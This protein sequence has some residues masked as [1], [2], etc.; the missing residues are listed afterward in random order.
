MALRKIPIADEMILEWA[1]RLSAVEKFLD[2][3][4][5]PRWREM[6]SDYEGV[7]K[8]G[9]VGLTGVDEDVNFN[10]LLA[11]ANS[12]LPSI[13][14]TNPYIRTK[15]RRPGDEDSA[16]VAEATLNYLWREIRALDTTQE[17]TLDSLLF[18]LGVGKVGYDDSD[19]F[20]MADDYDQGPQVGTDKEA[21][22]DPDQRRQLLRMMMEADVPIVTD[23]DD[24]VPIFSRVAPWNFLVP[25]GYDKPHKAPWLAERIPFILEDL[26]ADSRFSVPKDLSA[27]AWMM[28][29]IPASLS[30]HDPSNRH[31]EPDVPADHIVVYEIRYWAR[32]KN[33]MQRRILWMIKPKDGISPQ[34]CVLRHINDPMEISGY[35]YRTMSFVRVPG[36]IYTTTTSDLATIQ[37]ASSRLNVEWNYLLSHH[38][39]SSKRKYVAVQGVMEGGQLTSL[40]ESDQDM[41]VA[42]LP[43]ATDDIRKVIM[44]LPE[45]PPPSTTMTVLQ[46]LQ[47]MMYELSGVDVY[48]RGGV[49]RKGTT[50]TEVNVAA[51]GSGNRAGVRLAAVELF[52]EDIA[53]MLLSVVRQYWDEPR[54]MRIVG[55]T[56]QD[57]FAVFDSS[58]VAQHLDVTI[59]AGSA[60]GKDPAEE[61][62]AYMGLMTTIDKTLMTF[63][64]LAQMGMVDDQTVRKYLER[65]FSLWQGN[66][67]LMSPLGQLVGAGAAG[68]TGG[69][70][71]GLPPAEAAMADPSGGGAQ[72]SGPGGPGAANT[73]GAPGLG[74]Q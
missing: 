70:G 19:A 46:G 7:P 56:G 3:D 10:F 49:G 21:Q 27:D 64:Q 4:I 26:R 17:V 13:V 5:L 66:K 8:A 53:K 22:L 24:D 14:S 52:M 20:L 39:K 15:P 50:A 68:A 71:P 42:E 34:D 37:A 28:D 45:A 62:Q 9:Q 44:L 31:D 57:E 29:S 6:L 67:G 48:Q 55:E 1:E 58:K 72:Q 60:I 47:K 54:H 18:N 2:E 74:G 33:M 69:G 11:T 63:G 25:P 61:A 43:V 65:A 59:E 41:E 32:V 40:L 36:K 51:Q 38:E 16:K 23:G 30:G 73:G 35:P 12:L